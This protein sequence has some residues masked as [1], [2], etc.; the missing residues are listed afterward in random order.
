MPNLTAILCI[1][2]DGTLID[3]KEQ[4]H[5]SDIAILQSFPAN[6]QPVLTT[7]RI[8]HSA[9]GV[10]QK[11]NLFNGRPIPLPGV[12]MNGGVAYLPGE[13]IIL[14]HT[15]NHAMRQ[16]LLV[17]AERHPHSCFTF[18][19]LDAVHLI[20]PN[21]FGRYI[22]D[23][24]YLAA[25][26]TSASELPKEIVK[27][28]VLDENVDSLSQIAQE[29]AGLDAEMAYSLK[30]AYEINPPGITKA[31]SLQVLLKTMRIEHL[32]VFVVGD[33]ENDLSLFRL[34]VQSFAPDTAHQA[35]LDHADRIISREPDGIL[36]PILQQINAFVKSPDS[37]PPS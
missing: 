12:F 3:E 6:I 17:V 8:L 22:S 13:R 27:L 5:P 23:L 36:T 32:P 15:F 21:P 11:F 1:D 18:F 20:N 24:H 14:Q 16:K 7:G 35:A 34:A 26:D 37:I 19:A 33:A 25:Q 10:L 28:M 31:N 9:K 2:I 29:T 30:F 4:L